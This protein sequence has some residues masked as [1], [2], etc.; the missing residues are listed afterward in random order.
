[1]AYLVDL[2]LAELYDGIVGG[3]EGGH[4]PSIGNEVLHDAWAGRDDHRAVQVGVEFIA[5]NRLD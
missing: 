4:F 5:E 1:M 3:G 2:R